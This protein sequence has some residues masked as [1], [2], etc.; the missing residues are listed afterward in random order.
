MHKISQLPASFSNKCGIKLPF[1]SHKHLNQVKCCK[2][3]MPNHPADTHSDGHA[4]LPAKSAEHACQA[5]N[6]DWKI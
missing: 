4:L 5:A 6:C 3:R 1:V 2:D